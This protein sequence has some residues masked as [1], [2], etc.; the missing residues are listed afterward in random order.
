MHSML[1]RAHIQ[2]WKEQIRGESHPKYTPRSIVLSIPSKG[3]GSMLA[4]G[5]P[6]WR[7]PRPNPVTTLPCSRMG[8][9][10][11]A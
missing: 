2:A 11:N 4:V 10:G 9:P 5:V 1:I 6:I 8:A 7:L 3:P